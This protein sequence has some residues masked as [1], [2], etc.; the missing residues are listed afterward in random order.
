MRSVS[1]HLVMDIDVTKWFPIQDVCVSRS[2]CIGMKSCAH[3]CERWPWRELVYAPGN[4]RERWGSW[5]PDIR[6]GHAVW[7]VNVSLGLCPRQGTPPT[8][9][10]G[11]DLAGVHSGTA[12]RYHTAGFDLMC[13]FQDTYH[14]LP[15]WVPKFH[16]L[17][18][19]WPLKLPTNRRLK[20]APLKTVLYFLGECWNV[21][22]TSEII[23]SSVT[24]TWT[25]ATF[26][27][28]LIWVEKQFRWDKKAQKGRLL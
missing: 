3:R 17:D 1:S 12:V 20:R 7:M 6:S 8:P 26:Q 16:I 5:K 2:G 24:D 18:L 28:P 27:F 15:K 10:W 9:L 19:S 23:Y 21:I 14:S 25:Q 22:Q 4:G 11:H 13:G